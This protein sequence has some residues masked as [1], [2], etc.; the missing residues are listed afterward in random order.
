MEGGKV[1]RAGAYS[2]H[3]INGTTIIIARVEVGIIKAALEL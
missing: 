3:S 2:A 1:S